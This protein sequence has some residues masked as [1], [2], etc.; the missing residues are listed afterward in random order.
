M[1][2]TVIAFGFTPQKT[3]NLID[4]WINFPVMP[5]IQQLRPI[6]FTA[7]IAPRNTEVTI[8]DERKLCNGRESL[9]FVGESAKRRVP[10]AP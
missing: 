2:L 5:V 4:L 8:I 1:D 3:K 6:I 7:K 9:P 10:F